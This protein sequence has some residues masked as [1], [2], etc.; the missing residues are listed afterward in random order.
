MG[1]L[2][3]LLWMLVI[4]IQAIVCFSQEIITLE[5][6]K[7]SVRTF[8]SDQ[9]LEFWYAQYREYECLLD[10]QECLQIPQWSID[11]GSYDLRAGEPSA[12]CFWSVD[13]ATGEVT[14]A[15]YGFAAPEMS[16]DVP[17]GP[18]SQA[19]CR[20]IAQRFA[21]AKYADFATMGFQLAV[22]R[23]DGFLWRFEWEQIVA[24]GA[25]TPNS[26]TVEVSPEDGAIG[27]YSSSRIPTPVPSA[28][29]IS[30]QQAIDIAKTDAGIVTLEYAETPTLGVDP[31][32]TYWGLDVRGLDVN[33]EYVAYAVGVD[34]VSGA[35]LWKY[36]MAITPPSSR[37]TISL[38]DL[39]AKVPGARVHWLGKE[40]ARLFIGKDR[41]ALV[42]GKDTIEWTGGTIKLS[43]KMKIVDGRLMVPSDLFDIL[44][45]A[46]APKKAPNVR[47]KSN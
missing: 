44:K 20:Q 24:Y 39:A 18:L 13:A 43:Q 42:P 23:W 6:A 45:A 15:Y 34:A 3:T 25:V 26:V 11:L 19:D 8:E 12:D 27:S 4:L 40:G 31:D 17:P 29:Q 30:D 38:R 37:S 10:E 35:V 5:Q 47:A 9:S 46:P 32:N 22:E 1:R 33:G 36:G 14:F 28:P 7:S 41:Y 21:N 2:A 16:T